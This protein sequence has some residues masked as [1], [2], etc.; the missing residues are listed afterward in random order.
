LG[1]DLPDE[2]SPSQLAALLHLA[3]A[4]AADQCKATD[5]EKRA[6]LAFLLARPVHAESGLDAIADVLGRKCPAIEPLEGA[7][8]GAALLGPAASAD[9]RRVL[10]D[11]ARA[12]AAESTGP[13]ERIAARSVYYLAIAGALVHCEAKIT[14]HSHR[15]LAIA[16]AAL[17]AKPWIEGPTEK[18][19]AA[20]GD[21]C[22][23]VIARDM[24]AG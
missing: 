20:A 2:P 21:L 3:D 23:L 6:A 22:R 18:L 10:K 24:Q 5:D 17:C 7:E 12:L 15:K 13:A 8:I 11:Y 1:T 14:N 16:L 19:L 4:D 9:A